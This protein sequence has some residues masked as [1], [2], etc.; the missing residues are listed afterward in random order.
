[1]H[2]EGL[3]WDG[4]SP[5]ASFWQVAHSEPP[6]P[7]YDLRAHF[8][9]LRVGFELGPRKRHPTLHFLPLSR[10]TTRSHDGHHRRCRCVLWARTLHT[11]RPGLS[12]FAMTLT[13]AT[14]STTD[15][16]HE[17]RVERPPMFPPT[18]LY[19][20]SWEDPEPDMEVCRIGH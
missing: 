13:L 9:T 5:L 6:D 16:L 12:T 11:L 15:A 7:V 19:T 2:L 14:F 17:E 10:C 4:P 3:L 8:H 18:F 20:Q 1:M